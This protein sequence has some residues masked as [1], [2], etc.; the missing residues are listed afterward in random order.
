MVT[1]KADDPALIQDYDPTWPETFSKLAAR[2]RAALGSLVITIEHIG[3]T[4]VPGLAAKPIIDIDVVLSSPAD[5]PEAIQLLGRIGYVHEGDLGIAGREAFHSPPGTSGHHLYVLSVGA[6]EL[7]RHLTFRDALRADSDLRDRYSALKRLLAEAY[8]DDRNSYTQ[9]KSAFI[10]SIVVTCEPIPNPKE[11]NV[12]APGHETYADAVEPL[13]A[14]LSADLLVAMKTRDKSAID[15]LRCL[16]AVLDNAG[17]Q[18]PA[19]APSAVVG[20]SAEVPRKSLTQTELQALMQ[21]EV[22][23]RRTAVIEYERGGRHQD[24]AHLRAELV[25]LNRYVDL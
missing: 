25:L 3:S 18:D 15:T 6:N 10:T 4:A 21:A 22:T 24:A 2:V 5:L 12:A 23:S 19:T 16:L 20:L 17:A 8:K 7:R 11:R 1:R 14:R 13:R 9:A